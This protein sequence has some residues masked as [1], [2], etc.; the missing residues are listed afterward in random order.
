VC[1]RLRLEAGKG[2]AYKTA[3]KESATGASTSPAWP[4]MLAW[5]FERA[6]KPSASWPAI[7]E[8]VSGWTNLKRGVTVN[9]GVMGGGYNQRDSGRPGQRSDVRVA[10]S[11]DAPRI[12]RK[13]AT[14]SRQTKE[15]AHHHGGI[16]PPPMMRTRGSRTALSPGRALA[17]ELGF[18]SGRSSQRRRP[19]TANSPPLSAFLPWTAWGAVGEGAHRPPRNPSWS[20]IWPPEPPCWRD[21]WAD[22]QL[23]QRLIHFR[24]EPLGVN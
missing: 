5:T 18:P 8:T 23:P 21:C 10:S 6:P 13:F 1:R 17:A 11:A 16:N 19:L 14:P 24:E 9:L 4:H 22:V 15:Y 2:L 12:E 7:V 3:R 20:S